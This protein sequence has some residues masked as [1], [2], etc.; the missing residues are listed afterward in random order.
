MKLVIGTNEDTKQL[1]KD[2]YERLR[3]VALKRQ[4]QLAQQLDALRWWEFAKRCAIQ[5]RMAIQVNVQHWC[6][7]QRDRCI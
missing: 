7:E 6:E 1:F 3:R 5:Y 4:T 2:E